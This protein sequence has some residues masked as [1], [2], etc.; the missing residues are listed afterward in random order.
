M[1]GFGRYV[2]FVCRMIES[3]NENE[4]MECERNQTPPKQIHV[5]FELKR[6]SYNHEHKILLG[7]KAIEPTFV[8]DASNILM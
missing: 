2:D 3:K 7:Q 5:E 8:F 4:K 1:E 6:I